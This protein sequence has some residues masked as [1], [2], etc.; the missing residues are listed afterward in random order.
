MESLLDRYVLISYFFLNTSPNFNALNTKK[1]ARRMGLEASKKEEPEPINIEIIEY[2]NIESVL[3]KIII[4]FSE[5]LGAKGT[6]DVYLG[7]EKIP[8]E[9]RD[10]VY[11]SMMRQEFN[12]AMR[13]VRKNE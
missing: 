5:A 6:P 12:D 2:E 4:P 7:H 1:R 8:F 13:S 3:S 11:K 9:Q 10:P